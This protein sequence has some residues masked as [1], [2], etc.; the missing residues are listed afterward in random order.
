MRRST[1]RRVLVTYAGSCLAASGDGSRDGS[2]GSG[3]GPTAVGGGLGL[4]IRRPAPNPGHVGRVDIGNM[5]DM[6]ET[7]AG[8][9]SAWE[10][11]GKSGGWDWSGEGSG[12]G[13]SLS[14][15]CEAIV[16]SLKKWCVKTRMT[17][18]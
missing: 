8:S 10:S 1:R 11:V 2:D 14:E 17:Q 9:A 18:W 12:M 6:G 16:V 15:S 3:R 7:G 4:T 5:E 13:I